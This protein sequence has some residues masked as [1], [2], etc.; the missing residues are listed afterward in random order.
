[1]REQLHLQGLQVYRR[2]PVWAR[3]RLVRTISPS[4]TVGAICF[5]ERDD[6]QLLLVR[7][8]Y[9]DRWGVPGGLL[10]RGEDAADGARR[11]VFEEVGV[12][13]DLVGEPTV[14]V[15][16]EP[17]RVDV[18]YRARLSRDQAP[19]H[20]RACSPEI[21]AVAWFPTDG[22]PELQHETATALAALT[23][24]SDRRSSLLGPVVAAEPQRH[25]RPE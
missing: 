18:I 1:V 7:L 10:E 14:V 13:V 12:A 22:L 17:R 15:D 11:E 2:L 4:F 23:R 6:G 9:R 5:I 24:A 16:P 8:V 19:E 3:R 20:V 21:A 25:R